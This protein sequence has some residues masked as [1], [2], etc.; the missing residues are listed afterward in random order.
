MKKPQFSSQKKIWPAVY[1]AILQVIAV[2]GPEFDLAIRHG[3]VSQKPGFS[4]KPGFFQICDRKERSWTHPVN[5]VK[6]LLL[7][8]LL[9]ALPLRQA[10]ACP[11]HALKARVVRNRHVHRAASRVPGL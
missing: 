5:P 10:N 1:A 4:K 8:V 2:T 3:A 6:N 7:F 11:V 9:P